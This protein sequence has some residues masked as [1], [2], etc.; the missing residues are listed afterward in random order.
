M[1]IFLMNKFYDVNTERNSTFKTAFGYK[2]SRNASL[3]NSN[4]SLNIKP[5]NVNLRY[6]K[7]TKLVKANK[8]PKL[9]KISRNCKLSNS[10]GLIAEGG[11]T[12]ESKHYK[13]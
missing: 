12:Q 3:V 2:N 11:K 13:Q 7:S 9:N 4:R 10:L 8:L 6:L 5:N 1:N